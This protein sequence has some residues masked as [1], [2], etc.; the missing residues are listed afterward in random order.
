MSTLH[1]TQEKHPVT[2]K[3]KY[4]GLFTGCMNIGQQQTVCAISGLPFDG[5][6]V[7]FEMRDPHNFENRIIL[8]VLPQYIPEAKRLHQPRMFRTTIE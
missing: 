6:E 4:C 2:Y 7:T 1:D 8:K 3:C 5:T